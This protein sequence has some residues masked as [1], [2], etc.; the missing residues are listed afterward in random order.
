MW[1]QI[2]FEQVKFDAISESVK[3]HLES[4]PSAIDSFLESHILESTHYRI[5]I[6]EEPAGFTSVH[7]E[8]LLTQFALEPRYRVCGQEVFAQVKKLESVQAAF[9]P[10]C[11]EFFLAH[12]LDNYRQLTKQAYFFAVSSEVP[13]TP[14]SGYSLRPAVEAD[15]DLIGEESG[16][17][18]S[19]IDK[20]ISQEKLFVTSLDGACISFG[21]WEK[22]ELLKDVASIGMFVLER[23]RRQGAGTATL[24]LLRKECEKQG[25]QPVAGCWYYNHASKK[26]LERANMFTQTR[27]LK[28]DF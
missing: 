22:S 10:T 18:F 12:A 21:I 23:F 28:I 14:Q 8:S 1:V 26:T 13:T 24:L 2:T 5:A 27:L 7:K 17:F 4:L 9:V 20:L 15:I 3:R 16:D 25:L 19:D 6:S 11:D